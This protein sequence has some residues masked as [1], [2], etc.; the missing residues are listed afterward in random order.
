MNT[1]HFRPESLP[2]DLSRTHSEQKAYFRNVTRN[3]GNLAHD[4]SHFLRFTDFQIDGP[5]LGTRLLVLCLWI[6]CNR[7]DQNSH[8]DRFGIIVVY[9]APSTC[10]HRSNTRVRKKWSTDLK[11]AVIA[12]RCLTKKILPS[13][14]TTL[15]AFSIILVP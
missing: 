4:I 13:R 1:C 7:Y 12:G 15:V 14:L 11:I 5:V 8:R 9:F 10:K 2:K 3:A 6:L